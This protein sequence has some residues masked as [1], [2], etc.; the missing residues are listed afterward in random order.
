VDHWVTD[1]WTHCTD[2]LGLFLFFPVGFC[3]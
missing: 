3:A 1:E 2:F